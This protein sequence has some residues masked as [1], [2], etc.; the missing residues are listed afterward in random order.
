[1]LTARDIF[2]ARKV[3]RLVFDN[4]CFSGVLR[5]KAGEPSAA[6]AGGFVRLHRAGSRSGGYFPVI[7]LANGG[8]GWRRRQYVVCAPQRELRENP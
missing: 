2:R 1:M 6:R 5:G 3:P 8:A 4:A 7:Y